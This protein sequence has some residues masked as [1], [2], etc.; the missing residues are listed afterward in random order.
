MLEARAPGRPARVD[1]EPGRPALSVVVPT[2]RFETARA[3][4]EALS[5]QTVAERIELVM[6][7]PSPGDGN[8]DP[9]LEWMTFHSVRLVEQDPLAPYTEARARGVEAAG[10]DLVA[11]TETHSFPAPG[12]AEALIATQRGPWVAV[13]PEV[14][15][16][17]PEPLV[18]RVGMLINYGP[19]A[20]PA[21]PGPVE[22]VPGHNSCYE[23]AALLGYGPRLARMLEAESVLHWDLRRRGRRL[24]LQPA[25]RVRHRNLGLL[26][27]AIDEHFHGSRS[28][29]AAR[30]AGWAPPRRLVYALACPLLPAIRLAR[31]LRPGRGRR[32]AR[33]PLRALPPLLILLAAAAAGELAGYLT[34]TGNSLDRLTHYE[35]DKG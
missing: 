5:A 17:N 16:E 3:V 33:P 35:I 25:A 12:W 20:A 11:F 19:W 23:R 15:N 34:G 28:F 6:V 18:S 21:K 31:V 30:A 26:R 29:A 24:Y 7:V 10:A 2:D 27:P 1:G 32:Y 22:H 14:E 4:V 9:A 8:G 13:G